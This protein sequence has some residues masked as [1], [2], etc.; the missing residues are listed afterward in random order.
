MLFRPTRPVRANVNDARVYTV[1]DT[2]HTITRT[3]GGSF[4]RA[5]GQ[6][7][8]TPYPE[9]R[10]IVKRAERNSGRGEDRFDDLWMVD[11]IHAHSITA[12]HILNKQETQGPL[13]A[14]LR[15]GLYDREEQEGVVDMSAQR[16]IRYSAAM[17]AR[18]LEHLVDVYDK[19]RAQLR[20]G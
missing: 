17:G 13:G 9:A 3:T 5:R 14:F 18:I 7:R 15:R 12:A 1:P 6:V 10:S 16:S 11:L 19:V 2:L 20:L 8:G 4:V